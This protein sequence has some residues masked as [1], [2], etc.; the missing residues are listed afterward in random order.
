MYSFSETPTRPTLVQKF[1]FA[2]LR[3]FD[4]V[5]E[6]FWVRL[7]KRWIPTHQFP[8]ISSSV[9]LIVENVLLAV[10][11]LHLVVDDDV[12]EE[13]VME[14][15]PILCMV[16]IV[17]VAN[18]EFRTF[19]FVGVPEERWVVVIFIVVLVALAIDTQIPEEDESTEKSRPCK[20]HFHNFPPTDF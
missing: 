12:V 6:M 9:A 20:P 3:T 14:A 2:T 10:T 7:G 13:R 4:G 15:I 16:I 11:T 1:S 17:K 8:I 5:G 19:V 18:V